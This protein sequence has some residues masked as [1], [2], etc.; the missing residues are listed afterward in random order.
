MPGKDL[1][2]LAHC[3]YM[4]D[5][6]VREIMQSPAIEDKDY[7]VRSLMESFARVLRREGYAVTMAKLKTMLAYAG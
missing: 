6:M 7:A 3:L 1:H 5:L 2:D 4:F